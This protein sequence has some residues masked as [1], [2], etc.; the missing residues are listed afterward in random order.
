LTEM[1]L[2]LQREVVE[3]ITAAPGTGERGYLSV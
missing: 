3:R 1:I 2:M